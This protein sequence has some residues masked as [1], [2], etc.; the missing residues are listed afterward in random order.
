MVCNNLRSILVL[1]WLPI[2]SLIRSVHHSHS[3]RFYTCLSTFRQLPFYRYV[4]LGQ[5]NRVGLTVLMRCF[6]DVPGGLVW[7]WTLLLASLSCL[8]VFLR[9]WREI[10]SALVSPDSPCL[11]RYRYTL[12]VFTDTDRLE[13]DWLITV[14]ATEI[15]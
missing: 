14:P 10:R 7:L 6:C 2:R 15:L 13:D 3:S 11:T 8:L 4:P 1:M 12:L 5:K 9:C